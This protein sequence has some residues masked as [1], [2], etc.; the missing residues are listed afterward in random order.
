MFSFNQK[1]GQT[2]G[3]KER[4]AFLMTHEIA[5]FK[6]PERLE[7]LA[8]FPVST[9]G[10]VSKKILGEWITAKLKK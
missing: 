2:L 7:E 9:F 10:K 4:V 3:L 5:T 8:D 6:L 1:R